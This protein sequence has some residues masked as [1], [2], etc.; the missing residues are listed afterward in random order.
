M[1][2]NIGWKEMLISQIFFAQKIDYNAFT[3]TLRYTLCID[4]KKLL[5]EL[6]SVTPRVNQEGRSWRIV[7]HGQINDITVVESSRNNKRFLPKKK[8]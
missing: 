1:R 5:W 4:I 3:R 8:P 2:L 7:L 6:Q